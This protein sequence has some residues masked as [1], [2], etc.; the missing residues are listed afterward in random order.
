MTI[1]ER[2]VKQIY[3]TVQEYRDDVEKEIEDFVRGS[4]TDDDYQPRDMG[5][6]F[7]HF[8]S[9]CLDYTLKTRWGRYR[10]QFEYYLQ[11]LEDDGVIT[12]SDRNRAI[13]VFY[14]LYDYPCNP[15]CWQLWHDAVVDV[16]QGILPCG[17]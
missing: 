15:S 5:E 3:K 12:G 8:L 13:D 16:L 17:R 11:R 2:R 6:A 10:D 14:S 9:G 1:A 7:D 4:D